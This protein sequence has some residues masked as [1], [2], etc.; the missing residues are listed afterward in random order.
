M[1]L[2]Y[3]QAE[4]DELIATAENQVVIDLASLCNDF[5]AKIAKLTAALTAAPVCFAA[6]E[7]EGNCLFRFDT[8]SK[9]PLV[10]EH[11]TT[12]CEQYRKLRTE[13]LGATED[14]DV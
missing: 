12:K 10:I 7:D 4:R 11:H 9:F 13:A 2:R 6:D 8:S 14:T 5:E 3:N 1:S